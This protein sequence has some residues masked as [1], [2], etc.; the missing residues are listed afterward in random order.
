MEIQ[1]KFLD[2]LTECNSNERPTDLLTPDNVYMCLDCGSAFNTPDEEVEPHGEV[3][4]CCPECKSTD[5]DDMVLCPNCGCEVAIRDTEEFW[6]EKYTSLLYI[7]DDCIKQF[8][9]SE[10]DGRQ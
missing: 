10:T 2:E 3:L 7:C 5:F 6:S 8:R 4:S 1:T 9:R